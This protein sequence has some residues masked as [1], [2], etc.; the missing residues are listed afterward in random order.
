MLSMLLAVILHF[1]CWYFIIS[2]N[3][4]GT[5]YCKWTV[6]IHDGFIMPIS[7][8]HQKSTAYKRHKILQTFFWHSLIKDKTV[9]VYTCNQSL[10]TVYTHIW[11]WQYEMNLPCMKK[12]RRPKPVEL[13]RDFRWVEWN[14]PT[15]IIQ[16]GH[17]HNS[18]KVILT[19]YFNNNNNIY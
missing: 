19:S 15:D 11:S 12:Q 2:C 13:V 7:H 3:Q 1:Y 10:N 18:Y 4:T 17:L 6:N 9:L 16:T 14:H 8:V 5:L